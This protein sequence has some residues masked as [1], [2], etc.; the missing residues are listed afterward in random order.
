MQIELIAIIPGEA[1]S[2]KAILRSQNYKKQLLITEK[3]L[4][5]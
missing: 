1:I 2:S 3:A 5:T 4:C